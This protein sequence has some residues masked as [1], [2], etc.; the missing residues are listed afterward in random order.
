MQ[1]EHRSST[2]WECFAC[3]DAETSAIFQSPQEFIG[4]INSEHSNV[5]N[6]EDFPKMLRACQR[7]KPLAIEACPLCVIKPQDDD[8][9]PKV[10]LDHIADHIH[11]FSLASLPWADNPPETMSHPQRQV[12]QKVRNW[13]DGKSM[14]HTSDLDAGSS[15]PSAA[16]LDYFAESDGASSRV[17]FS[18]PSHSN[19]SLESIPSVEETSQKR[20]TVIVVVSTPDKGI[21]SIPM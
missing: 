10:L 14:D 4:H 9:D 15:P 12:L 5:T 3:T 8:L 11:D 2:Y 18:S 13:L 20:K 6:K 21:V 19:M 16:L 1:Q 7:T 17:N